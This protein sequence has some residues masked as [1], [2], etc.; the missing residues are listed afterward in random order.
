MDAVLWAGEGLMGH[1]SM[2]GEER[3]NRIGCT[4]R[5]LSDIGIGLGTTV[6]E[7]G[8]SSATLR[9]TH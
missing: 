6:Y 7:Y 3:E 8:G 2:I 9:D 4:D 5:R 1:G